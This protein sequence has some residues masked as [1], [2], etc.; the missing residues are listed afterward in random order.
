MAEA[1]ELAIPVWEHIIHAFPR[2]CRLLSRE[3]REDGRYGMATSVV[4]RSKQCGVGEQCGVHML[5]RIAGTHER[6]QE[7]RHG[8]AGIVA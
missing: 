7:L 8:K 4:P 6:Q 5:V 2:S 3:H 1:C